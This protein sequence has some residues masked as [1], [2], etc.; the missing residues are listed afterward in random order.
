MFHSSHIHMPNRHRQRTALRTFF[1]SSSFSPPDSKEP[2]RR[3]ILFSSVATVL[4]LVGAILTWLG[5]NDVFGGKIS[6]TGPLLI[7]LA[8]L[9]LLLS[10]RQ[11]MLARKRNRTTNVQ[12]ETMNSGNGIPAGTDQEDMNGTATIVVESW[13]TDEPNVDP[14]RNPDELAPPSYMD[15]AQSFNSNCPSFF[16][17]DDHNEAPP[18]YEETCAGLNTYGSETSLTQLSS[19][20]NELSPSPRRTGQQGFFQND[21]SFVSGIIK[22]PRRSSNTLCPSTAVSLSQKHGENT[23]ASQQNTKPLPSSTDIVSENS[24]FLPPSLPTVVSSPETSKVSEEGKDLISQWSRRSF[25][26]IPSYTCL[27]SESGEVSAHVYNTSSIIEEMMP[28]EDSVPQGSSNLPTRSHSMSS[29]HVLRQGVPYG[30]LSP[31]QTQQSNQSC[32]CPQLP[33]QPDEHAPSAAMEILSPVSNLN[34]SSPKLNSPT[35]YP[36]L[37]KTSDSNILDLLGSQPGCTGQQRHFTEFHSTSSL[38]NYQTVDLQ[39]SP[40]YLGYTNEQQG[41]SVKENQKKTESQQSIG[42]GNVLDV[43]ETI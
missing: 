7:A 34:S 23:I 10:F 37:R 32:M 20:H 39:D 15:I 25:S 43:Q 3:G 16:S 2:L 26:S 38:G 33:H 4:L 42:H 14:V 28:T 19:R 35:Y 5:F 12:M 17:H 6:M 24:L 9:M 21:P 40:L 8:L 22:Q 18:T 36:H 1:P 29:V 11:F 30:N 13:D 27:L 31:T 41:N